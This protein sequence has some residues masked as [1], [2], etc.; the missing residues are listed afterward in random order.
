MTKIKASSVEK[1]FMIVEAFKDGD[2]QLD[3]ES[4]AK[5]TGLNK[6]TI[7]RLVDSLERYGYV[8]RVSQGTY[9]LGPA[10]LN[11]ASL[12]QSSFRL[13]DHTY[14]ILRQLVSDTGQSAA[15]FIRENDMRVCLHKIDSNTGDLISRLK[16][17]DRRPILPGGTGRVM[18]AFSDKDIERKAYS[19]ISKNYIAFNFGERSPEVFSVVAPAFKNNQLLAGVVSLSGPNTSFSKNLIES[20]RIHVLQAAANLTKRLGGDTHPFE[21]LIRTNEE[22]FF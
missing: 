8:L 11:F 4:L 1:A 9:A 10:F 13:S 6:A 18:M 3:L 21:S 15:F 12:Y 20:Y 22:P 17:G 2:G 14:P 16:E 7:I 5:C 19:E